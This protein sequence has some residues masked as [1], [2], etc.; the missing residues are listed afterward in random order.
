MMGYFCGSGQVAVVS[1]EM[2]RNHLGF[3]MISE[4]FDFAKER[5][6]NTKTIRGAG[7]SRSLTGRR[8][9]H[10]SKLGIFAPM[11]NSGPLII[12]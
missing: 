7:M 4:C 6:D 12:G 1:K 5:L 8:F 2:G 3:E 10:C 9:L 11:F